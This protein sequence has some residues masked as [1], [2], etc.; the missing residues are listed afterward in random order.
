[1]SISPAAFLAAASG[2]SLAATATGARLT[3]TDSAAATTRFVVARLAQAGT[4]PAPDLSPYL[5]GALV[6]LGVIAIGTGAVQYRRFCQRLPLAV[7]P[8]SLAQ[9]LALMLAWALVAVGALLGVA[10][11]R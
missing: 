6:A 10:V 8:S 1:M 7:R 3:Y 11:L 9:G 2:A 5:G 4:V